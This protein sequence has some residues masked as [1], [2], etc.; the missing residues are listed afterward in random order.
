MNDDG[1]GIG[2]L[3]PLQRL[4]AIIVTA[5]QAIDMDARDRARCQER[6][7]S[8]RRRDHADGDNRGDRDQN[9]GHAPE[10]QLATNPAAVDDHI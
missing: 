7:A 9:R 1:R 3:Q 5:D 6:A 4:D 2:F 10:G 8:A